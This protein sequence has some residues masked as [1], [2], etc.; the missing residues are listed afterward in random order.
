MLNDLKRND[1]EGRLRALERLHV[2]DT[3]DQEPFD[4]I[5]SLVRQILKVPMST[6][7]LVDRERQWFKAQRGLGFCQTAR[8]ISFCTHAIG[9][10]TPFIIRD[11][12]LDDRFS[13]SPLVIGE[14]FIRSY[15]GI[16]LMTLDGYNVGALCAMDT[17]PRAFPETEI[18]IVPPGVV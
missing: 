7:S 5:V 3:A 2:L 17:R 9:E 16:P 12:A 11:A 10:T 6:V 14:P 13:Q 15:A 1:E 8:D 18:S 4:K